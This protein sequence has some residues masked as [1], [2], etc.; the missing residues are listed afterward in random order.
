MLLTIRV[1][2]RKT[3]NCFLSGISLGIAMQTYRMIKLKIIGGL[4][5]LTTPIFLFFLIFIPFPLR[6][7]SYSRQRDKMTFL[8]LILSS[9]MGPALNNGV[10]ATMAE[11]VLKTTF[12][13]CLSSHEHLSHLHENHSRLACW[14]PGRR[15]GAKSP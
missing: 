3:T 6:L 4:I 9:G 8:P 15:S 5:V 14:R 2:K 10:L 13:V 11:V 1:K 12:A 7:C